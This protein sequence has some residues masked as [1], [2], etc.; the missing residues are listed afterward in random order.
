[1]GVRL[2]AVFSTNR[3]NSPRHS[4]DFYFPAFYEAKK[5]WAYR[6]AE[7]GHFAEFDFKFITPKH[8]LH[9]HFISVHIVPSDFKCDLL[10]ASISIDP[11]SFLQR[12]QINCYDV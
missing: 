7:H 3:Q 9:T 1:L 6:D 8:A 11:L 4:F 5:D 2:H 10:V 12:M